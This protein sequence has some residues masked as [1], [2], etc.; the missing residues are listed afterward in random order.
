[1]VGYYA[2]D[3]YNADVFNATLACSEQKNKRLEA[4]QTRIR[5]TL[6]LTMTE[7]RKTKSKRPLCEE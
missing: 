3:P 2:V 4:L 7:Y 6:H 1:M 5:S